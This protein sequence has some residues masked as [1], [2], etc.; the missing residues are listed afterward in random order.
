M[1]CGG[2]IPKCVDCNITNSFFFN[3]STNLFHSEITFSTC[4]ECS[5]SLYWSPGQQ[6]C[7]KCMSYE[8]ENKDSDCISCS[9]KTDNCIACNRTYSLT[10]RDDVVGCLN[11]SF[12]YALNAKSECKSCDELVPGCFECYYLNSTN[13]NCTLCTYG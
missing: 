11:C 3:T 8:Y 13:V 5:D 7:S 4:F 9:V 10:L 1:A 2:E 6:I 12:G